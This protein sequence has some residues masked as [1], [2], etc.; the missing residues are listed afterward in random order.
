M[1]IQNNFKERNLPKDFAQEKMHDIQKFLDESLTFTLV[2]IPSVGVSLFLKFLASHLD[3]FVVYLDTYS[4]LEPTRHGFYLLFADALGIEVTATLSDQEIL[5]RCKETLSTLVKI[6]GKVVLIFNRFELLEKELTAQFLGSLRLLP[7]GL[8][9]SVSMIFALTKPFEDISLE[10]LSGGNADVFTRYY[11]FKPYSPKD[12]LSLLQLHN[13]DLTP[14]QKA[15]EQ[16]GGHFQLFQLLL[17]TEKGKVDPLREP[18]IRLLMKEIYESLSYEQRKQVQKIAQGKTREIDDYLYKV[19]LIFPEKQFFS[20]L[21]QQYVL[22]QISLKLPKKES[23][24]FI[25]LKRAK[26]EVVSKETIFREIW[27][28][29][30]EEAT[31]WALDSLIYR[32]RHNPTFRQSGYVLESYKKQGYILWKL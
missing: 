12:L 30:R 7:H 17:K 14:S 31:D 8:G 21:F 26:G 6:H 20:P 1:K 28:E 24:L 19:G 15:L 5:I 2:G 11:Y 22:S 13:P 29:H 16:S 25:I 9:G 32:L 27:Q 18:F 4:I 3:V 10:S 23:L